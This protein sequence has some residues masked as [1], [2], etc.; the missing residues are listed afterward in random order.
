MKQPQQNKSE[1]KSGKKKSENKLGKRKAKKNINSENNKLFNEKMDI[2]NTKLDLLDKQEELLSEQLDGIKSKKRKLNKNVQVVVGNSKIKKINSAVSL[3]YEKEFEFNLEEQNTF[4]PTAM[5]QIGLANGEFLK[6]RGFLDTGAQPNGICYNLFNDKLKGMCKSQP[7]A[8]KIIGI[9]GQPFCIK[10]KVTLNIYSW[11]DTEK[12]IKASFW[13]MPKN[14]GWQPCMPMERMNPFKNRN[15]TDRPFADPKYWIPGQIQLLFGIGFFAN[16]I[17]SVVARNINGTALMD[18]VLGVIIFGT[19]SSEKETGQ[20]LSAIEYN[21]EEQ[22]DWLLEKLWRLDEIPMAPKFT[23]EELEVEKHFLENFKRNKDGKFIVKMPLKE[24]NNF[25]S[26]R[27]I[28]LK[29]F[30]YLER[31]LNKDLELKSIYVDKMRESIQL[32]HMILANQNP[33][34]GDLVY[35]V[36]HHCI[37][38]DNRI[39]YDASCKTDLGVSLNEIQMLGP[40]LQKDMFDTIMRFRRHRIAIYGDI[41][42]M[43]NQVLLAREQWDLQRIF[44]REDTSES[45]RE[46]WLTV[47]IFGEKISPF[48]AVRSIFQAAREA[49]AEYPTAAKTIEDDYYMDDCVTGT[50]TIE[51]AI[52]LAKDMD[53]ILKGA[54]FELRK[55]KSN[56]EAVVQALHSDMEKAMLFEG[57]EKSTILGLKWLIEED[58]FTFI[59]RNQELN[60]K[61]TKRAISIHVARLYDPNGYITPVTIRGRML[62]QDLWK[63]KIGWDETLE[64]KWVDQWIKIWEDII[65]LEQ[66]RIDRWLGTGK[67]KSIQLHGFSDSSRAAYGASVYVRVQ[68][69]EGKVTSNLLTS[70]SRLAPIKTLSITRLELSAAELLSRLAKA[71]KRSMEWENVEYFL[72]TD[73]SATYFWIKRQPYTLKTFVANRVASIQEN[74]DI[75]RWRHINGKDNPADLITRGIAPLQLVD[76]KLWINGPNW[77]CKP[78]SEWPITRVMGNPPEEAMEEVRINTITRF[79][80]PLCIGLE[81]TKRNVPLLDYTGKLEKAVNIISYVNRFIKIRLGKLKLAKKRNRRGEIVQRIVPPSNEEKTEAMLHLIRKSQQEHFNKDIT[82]IMERRSLP[83]NSIL[84]PMKPILDRGGLL[85]LGGRLS[86][87]E[88]DYEMKHPFIIPHDSRLAYLIMD[89]AHRQ[90]QHG[91]VQIMMHFIR[92]KYWIAKLRNGLR[93]IVHK[94]VVCV[95]LNARMETQLMSDLPKERIQ[96]G[97][98]FLTTGVDYAGPFEVKIG[99][100]LTDAQ[101]QKCWIAIFVCLKTRAMHIEIVIGLSAVAFIACYERF[102]S[103]RGRC[104]KL[105]SDNGTSF[106][107]T[108][109]E[110][111][112][113][114][115]YWTGKE[116]LDHLHSRG[117]EWQ[118]MTPAAPHQGGIYEAAVKSM[119]FH[120]KRTIGVKILTYENLSTLLCQIEAILNSRPLNPLS[121]DPNDIQAL[122]PGHFLVGEPLITPLPFIIDPKPQSI[123]IRLWRDRQKMV[124][125]FW[126][127]WK[128]EYLVTLQERKKW[129]REKENIKVGQL[130]VIKAENFPPTSWALGRV[131]EVIISRDGLI[132][133]VVVQTATTQLK[134]PVQKLCI[135]P[136]E[137]EQ[138]L[139]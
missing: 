53:R 139:N 16:V 48:L 79:K 35:Y 15:T 40:K 29:R 84:E 129:R 133:N 118:F 27:E 63:I 137:L 18:T 130:V 76:N 44:W 83:E 2:V 90:T 134:R 31:K 30:F 97:K 89:Y 39:V 32:G 75:S 56:S 78:P 12:A 25:G 121:D 86:R 113:A 125:H 8:K 20:I 82:A 10:Q 7:M 112:K 19:D 81:G 61:V 43:Y 123:G 3:P 64:E 24:I 62:L 135:L 105:F 58:K 98:P 85:R 104:E 95:R 74:T 52:K 88:M 94:C 1:N 59:V 128:E 28:A 127:R 71:V 49:K 111:K 50:D 47:V 87:A 51:S 17:I 107:G 70:K 66:F 41:K 45:I 26:S 120:L 72:W 117:T 65:C 42:K 124:Q 54:G 109:K 122:T 13:I 110:L 136:I 14:S 5:V 131:I 102:I 69:L 60:G 46:Y 9:D 55:W 96:I 93:S 101:Y 106:V 132:R 91:G 99:N 11:F 21:E 57:E 80:D 114:M 92:Q 33:R 77:L 73:S 37:P 38:K 126:D 67:E 119:K 108:E 34:A 4:L 116:M 115:E 22:L 6:V 103:R 100:G 36:P 23:K 138:N 68:T